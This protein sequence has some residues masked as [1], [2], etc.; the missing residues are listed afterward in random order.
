MYEDE[1][2]NEMGTEQMARHV[3]NLVTTCKSYLD[4]QSKSRELALAYWNGEMPDVP[5]VNNRS[6]VTS[7]D[8]RSIIKKVLPSI[9]RTILGSDQI[10]EYQPVG[11]E[12]EEAAEQ[13]SDYINYVVIPECGA[14]QAIYDAV[15]DACLVKTGIL[16]WTAYTRLKAT[17]QDYT[18]QADSQVL[19]LIGDPDNEIMDHETSEE[20]D[21]EV[22]AL[23]P[24]ARRHS[25][26]LKRI[27]ESVDVLLEAVPRGSFLITPGAE[28]IADAELVG[29]E[30]T[31]TRSELV[32]MGYKKK[33]VWQIAEATTRTHDDDDKMAREGEDYTD[34]EAQSRKATQ[35]VTIYEVYVKLDADGDGIAEVH[36]IV[37][38]NPGEKGDGQEGIHIVLGHEVVDEA[39]YA[40]VVI[41]RDPH[42]FE[43]H[44]IYEDTREIQR[45][46]TSLLRSTLD[47]LYA[48][49][50]ARPIYDPSA[51]ENPEALSAPVFGEPIILGSGRNPKDSIH[52]DVVPFFADK[53]FAMLDYLDEVAKDRTGITDAS[54]GVDA[55]AFQNTTATAANLMSESG[56]VQADAIVRSVAR[57]GIRKAFRGL[58]KL[59]IAHTDQPRTVQM[60][61]E[62][63]DY[64]PRTWNSAMDC[65]INV[66]LGGGT[67]ERDMGVLQIVYNLQKEI[68]LSIGADNPYVKP[69]QLYNTL[70]KITE[71][72]GFAS[73]D[74]FFT[75]P[76]EQEVQARLQAEKN[77]PDPEQQKLQAQMQLEQMKMAANRDKESAQMEADLAV[78]RAEI[79]AKTQE[80]REALALQREQD[81]QAA[82][83][84]IAKMEADL[85]KHR[86]KIA[87]DRA[88]AV[89]SAQTKAQPQQGDQ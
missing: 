42:Q 6:S 7:N 1:D 4:E 16:K 39:P 74:P 19:G 73:S 24:N 5:I 28:S 76:D 88:N 79:E 44:S 21:P 35:D 9:T 57:G 36:R 67:K 2:S 11:P 12:D 71:T 47:N 25:F 70:S 8:T 80:N 60:K 14:E 32:S 77:K 82:Q 65:T 49:N 51:V 58:L 61:G 68:L 85:M 69:E 30:V 84:E 86:E 45:I 13:A 56:I 81:A 37:Y 26:K 59:V 18:D 22:L 27:D 17:V 15:H 52:W 78:K 50:N 48:Q 55:E 83:L 87:A 20:T 40:D 53:S 66:G 46:K 62:W 54:G 64:D 23:D 38:G 29:E 34:E 3:S 10:V 31:T 72:A 43:G 41:E 63:V 33:L 75:K 89:L